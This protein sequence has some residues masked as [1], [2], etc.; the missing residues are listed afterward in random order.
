MHGFW[1][2]SSLVKSDQ[3]RR[4]SIRPSAEHVSACGR[5]NEAPRRTREKTSGTQGNPS[6]V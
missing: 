5:Q 3:R 6:T 2:R 1:F 4:F